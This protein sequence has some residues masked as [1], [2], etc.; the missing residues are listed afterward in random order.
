MMNTRQTWKTASFEEMRLLY[1][2]LW[3]HDIVISSDREKSCST[4]VA[5][6]DFSLT[7]EMTGGEDRSE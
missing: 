3:N 1:K 4:K 2:S 5:L 7:V 6:K